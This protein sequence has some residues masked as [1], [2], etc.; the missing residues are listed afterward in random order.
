MLLRVWCYR[1]RAEL[2]GRKCSFPSSSKAMSSQ[3]PSDPVELRRINFPTAGNILMK[4]HVTNTHTQ[5]QS[6][7]ELIFQS[8]FDA[9]TLL[10]SKQCCL[11]FRFA[12]IYHRLSTVIKLVVFFG[13]P[14]ND[15]IDCLTPICSHICSNWSGFFILLTHLSHNRGLC[16]H[17]LQCVKLFSLLW[18]TSQLARKHLC[19]HTFHYAELS[20]F[21]F[22]FS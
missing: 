20:F 13:A 15:I 7:E 4:R 1:K 5:V 17:L 18:L 22:I 10:A 2:E 16:E 9:H 3:H 8:Q 21:V 6:P 11:S 12:C 14:A 19:T